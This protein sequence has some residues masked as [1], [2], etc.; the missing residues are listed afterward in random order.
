MRPIAIAVLLS[1]C[2][3]VFAVDREQIVVSAEK[4][5]DGELSAKEVLDRV[6]K[7]YADCSYYQDTGTV[8]TVTTRAK[9]K[10]TA[11]RTFATAF[12]RQSGQFRFEFQSKSFDNKDE[13]YIISQHPDRNVLSWWDLQPGVKSTRS[14]STAIA[15]ATGVSYGTASYVPSLLLRNQIRP[16]KGRITELIELGPI[17]EGMLNGVECYRIRG[18]HGHVENLRA[19]N[20][21]LNPLTIWIEKKSFLIRRVDDEVDLGDTHIQQTVLYNPS[22]NRK[23]D[24]SLL[25]FN[26]PMKK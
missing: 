2:F 23:V 6:A 26:P 3:F 13:K 5:L 16:L 25:E 4:T 18:M 1:L 11:K 12:A 21:P 17:E 10:Y 15:R 20:L 19:L 22:I 7:K 8:T 24:D 14:L 9:R